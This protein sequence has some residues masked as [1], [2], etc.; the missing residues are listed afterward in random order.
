MDE[1]EKAPRKGMPGAQPS[2]DL[3][4]KW[5]RAPYW[6]PEEGVAL[7]LGFDPAKVVMYRSYN[8]PDLAVDGGGKHY[9][10]LARRAVH[11]GRL[12]DFAGPA[13]FLTWSE[14]IGLTFHISWHDQIRP[15][16]SETDR[17]PEDAAKQRAQRRAAVLAHRQTLIRLWARAPAWTVREGIALRFDVSPD[18]EI[19]DRP[20]ETPP[21]SLE[22]K[23]MI[24]FSTRAVERGELSRKPA[25]AAFIKW[26]ESIGFPFAPEWLDAVPDA[27]RP[28]P[29][30]PPSPVPSSTPEKQAGLGAREQESLLKL[31]IGMA[32]AGYKYDPDAQRS[33]TTKEIADDLQGLGIGLDPDTVRKWLRIAA[34]VLPGKP[35]GA[36]D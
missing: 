32:I 7:A 3:L 20:S 36:D 1:I 24:E 26:A 30:A 10:D 5:A 13:D 16:R 8:T 33:P 31:V 17:S 9:A 23:R 29:A 14:S 25:P 11:V 2:D 15:R 4:Q 12:S 18:T 22:V 28:M 27:R 19:R 35:I 6:S 34:E 21:A